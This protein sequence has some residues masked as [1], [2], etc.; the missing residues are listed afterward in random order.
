MDKKAILIVD[1]QEINREIL[2]DVFQDDYLIYEAE[3]GQIALDELS[4]HHD[5]VAILLDLDMPVMDGL[6]MLRHMKENGLV[7]R[8]PTFI[9]TS[10]EEDSILEEAYSLGAADFI[11]KPFRA[12]FYRSRIRNSIELYSRR[13]DLQY[14][15]EDQSKKLNDFK[16]AM[17]ETL[18]TL[19]EFRDCE[20]GEHVRRICGLTRILIRRFA[21]LNPQY[22]L[23]QNEIEKIVSAAALHDVGKI[24]IPDA[25]LKKPG[26]LTK[27]EFD[28]IKTHTTKGCDILSQVPHVFDEGVFDYCYDICRHHHER[29]DGKGYP[30]GLSGEQITPWAQ[31][32]ALAD[33]YDALTSVRC[34]K[35]AYT[36]EEA[37]TM[38]LNGECG[39][40]QPEMLDI[41]RTTIHEVLTD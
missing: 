37:V 9:I 14:T 29:F 23:G 38:I 3:N 5:I 8:I 12:N 32:V 4:V 18:A 6:S 1:D 36:H 34:Y 30:D 20:S 11:P 13:N 26:R 39:S 7:N 10:S 40:F 2:I 31:V 33:V 35:P 27:D 19:I 17:I 16:S 21:E 22:Q 25:I 41:F 28:I 24:S 15:V